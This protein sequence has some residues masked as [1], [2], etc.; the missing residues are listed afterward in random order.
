[1]DYATPLNRILMEQIKQKDLSFL[2]VRVA[3]GKEKISLWTFDSVNLGPSTFLSQAQMFG[4]YA[5][6]A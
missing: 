1:M 5:N 2:H 3:M 4:C 6:N